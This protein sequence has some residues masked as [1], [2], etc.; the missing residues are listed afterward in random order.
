M[1]A[2]AAAVDPALEAAFQASCEAVAALSVAP[3]DEKHPEQD[4]H[5]W[6]RALKD[7][8]ATKP[9]FSLELVFVGAI[10]AVTPATAL[11]LASND[12]SA[13]A[14]AAPGLQHSAASWRFGHSLTTRSP[15]AVMLAT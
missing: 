10:A 9:I 14:T 5:R 7:I 4:W 13:V 15:K 11:T 2:A 6:A 1:A 12:L 3:L 8:V